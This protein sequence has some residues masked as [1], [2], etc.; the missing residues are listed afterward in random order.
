MSLTPK[1]Y[2]GWIPAWISWNGAEPSV[3]WCY[4]GGAHLSASFFEQS[5]TEYLRHPFNRLFR[6]RT[7]LA[8]MAAF[9]DTA[10]AARPAGF[11]F[12][13]SRCG[14]TL[15][16]RMLAALPQIMALSE[17]GPVESLLHAHLRHGAISAEQ[18]VLWFR[19]LVG[20]F[21]R[22]QVRDERHLF[23]KFDC[24]SLNELPIIQA[25]FPDVPCLFLYRD[26]I[27]V[28]VSHQRQPGRQMMP[29]ALEP[30][31]FGMDLNTA[32]A[33]PILDYRV[34]VLASLCQTAL[35]RA[36][37]NQLYLLHYNELP[38]ALPLL[39][40]NLFEI[41]TSD[42]DNDL[43]AEAARIDAKNPQAQFAPD[44]R[45]KRAE[46]SAEL[47]ATVETELS[48]IYGQLEALR[49]QQRQ[50]QRDGIGEERQASALRPSC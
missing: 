45:A 14:S 7:G 10:D 9:E 15:L 37:E 39:M 19:R 2:R 26:P 46:A 16:T 8:T 13:M 33:L 6:R 28:L 50:S 40:T 48:S 22:H 12:H 29:G 21:A 1:D 42:A 18:R 25:A 32:I 35:T 24:W 30:E 36:R 11:I 5:V 27:E 20:G 17:P 44:S 34:R 3:E 49:A 38:A 4:T 23:I 41:R 47:A 43:L 31:L